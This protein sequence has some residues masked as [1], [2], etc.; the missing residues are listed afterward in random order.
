MVWFVLSWSPLVWGWY[1]VATLCFTPKCLFISSITWK[2]SQETTCSLF[3]NLCISCQEYVFI[4]LNENWKQNFVVKNLRKILAKFSVFPFYKVIKFN[5]YIVL[6]KKVIPNLHFKTYISYNNFQSFIW[7]V[8][9]NNKWKTSKLFNLYVNLIF[10]TLLQKWD[11]LS[12]MMID[13]DPYLQYSPK[14]NL[15]V[16]WASFFG[17]AIASG[18]LLK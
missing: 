8:D 17:T 18:N 4:N 2:R 10:F 13:A 3:I 7:L 12:D 14:R 6:E 16:V 15:A 9:R 11:P 5:K 1:G